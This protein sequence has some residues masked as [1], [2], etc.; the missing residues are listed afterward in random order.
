VLVSE[1]VKVHLLASGIAV[2]EQGRHVLKGVPG[3]W[4]L[5]ATGD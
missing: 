3:E 4:P 2:S 5:F 1:A